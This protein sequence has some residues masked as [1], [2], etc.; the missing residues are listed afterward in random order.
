MQTGKS[1]I[2]KC[3]GNIPELDGKDLGAPEDFDPVISSEVDCVVE[4]II[5][6]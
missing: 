3:F 1:E 6:R 2:E 4:A 5:G